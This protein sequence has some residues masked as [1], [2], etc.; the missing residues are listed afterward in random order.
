[1]AYPSLTVDATPESS[2]QAETPRRPETVPETGVWD[3]EAGKW[4][5]A[6]KDAHGARDGERLLYRDDGTLYSRAQFVAGVQEGPFV[7]YHRDGSV[8]R[9]GRFVA[10]H[11]DGTVNAYASDDPRGERIR[12]CC[13]PPGAARLCERYRAGEFLLEIFYDRE[14]RAILSD[15]GLCP[16]RPDGL[17]DLAQYDEAR[18][19]WALRSRELDRSWNQDGK[20][21]EEVAYTGGGAR[22]VRTFDGAG[23]LMQECGFAA[24]DRADG[25]LYRRFPDGE[26]GPYA[27][28]RIREERGAYAG[29]QAIG[30]WTFMDADGQILRTVDRGVAFGDGDDA[31]A[32]MADAVDGDWL[33]RAHALAA[34]GRLREAFVLAARGAV[35]S[36]DRAALQR[37]RDDHVVPLTAEREAQWGEALSQSTD[38]GVA[39][40]LDGLVCG[41]DSAAAFR[42]L[43]SVLP[44]NH[45][46]ASELTE[47]SLL[48]AP[49]RRM[50]HLTRA[51][52]RLHRGDRDGALADAEIVAGE[53]AEA[54]DS[55]RTYVA[56]VFR[57]FDDWPWK[58]RLARDPELDGVTLELGHDLDDVR[59]AVGVYATR[60]A[61]LRAAL[62]AR[63]PAH[64]SAWLPP[65]TSHLLPT[66]EVT[67]RQETVECDPDDTQAEAGAGA[68][69]GEPAAPEVI[70]I[71]ERLATDDAA[72]P[73]LLAAAHADWAALSWLC[74]AVG[75]DR[76]A[77]PD[78]VA[79]RAELATATQLVVRRTWRI[80]DRL[81]S[82]G[83]ISRSQGV[84]GFDW[85]GVDIDA[86]PR[87]IAQMAA[88]EYIAVRSM[89]IW[90]ASAD[91]LSPFQDDIRDA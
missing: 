8:A 15:G 85:Q 32:L 12:S 6:R 62:R 34:G 31:G 9:E 23:R 13:V 70:E 7:V 56:A 42:A 90:L 87:H 3:A 53:S 48:L 50:T 58:E 65:D 46:A 18:G 81:T 45:P 63:V 21:T 88:H 66:G 84:P 73:A 69:A 86:L 78:A 72:V 24:D 91:A 54:A 74:W 35:A 37:F 57:A 44:G 55:L 59:H 19:G 10:G 38:V 82:G 75:L 27:D 11:V 60:L 89:L 14:G 36:G 64:A 30:R 47:A 29:G 79:A 4:E 22:I 41:A 83:L 39:A 25:S 49:E 28:A 51:L 1:M 61:R 2:A 17:P 33:A 77:L 80:K 76:V 26:P 16:A 20:L 40:V 68:G 71:D 52:L 67:L 5:V 43:A